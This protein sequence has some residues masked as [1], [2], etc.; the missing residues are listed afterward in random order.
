MLIANLTIQQQKNNNI[1]KYCIEIGCIYDKSD[2]HFM[3]IRIYKVYTLSDYRIININFLI[4][5]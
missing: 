4:K 1:G 3:I 2:F 5:N